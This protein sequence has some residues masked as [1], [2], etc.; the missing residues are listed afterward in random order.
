MYRGGP[1][2]AITIACGLLV[3]ACGDPDE[4]R[5]AS[6][7]DALTTI[8]ATQ[9]VDA[10]PDACEGCGAPTCT[11][12]VRNGDETGVDCGG[13]R[14]APCALGDAC[15]RH[16]D[17]ATRI[18]RLD[19]CQ[20]GRIVGDYEIAFDY[21]FLTPAQIR[22][23]LLTHLIHFRVTPSTAVPAPY[24]VFAGDQMAFE[25]HQAELVSLGHANG[26]RVL[27]AIAGNA[28]EMN[29]VAKD[30]TMRNAFITSVV[31]Y[32]QTHGYDG[33]DIDWEPPPPDHPDYLIA[34]ATELRVALNAWQPRG[35]L[36]FDV[37]C[38]VKT[39]AGIDYPTLAQ[40]ADQVNAMCYDLGGGDWTTRTAYNAA[41]DQPSCT[42]YDGVWVSK[43]YELPG[44]FST[45]VSMTQL[46]MGIPF[47]GRIFVGYS[48]PCQ[49]KGTKDWG[50]VLTPLDRIARDGLASLGL[51]WDTGA[52]VPWVGGVNGGYGNPFFMT[53]EDEQSIAAKAAYAKS[54]GVGGVM[55]W[56]LGNGIVKMPNGPPAQPLL[57]A[58]ANAYWV[59]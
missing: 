28:A 17:C 33:I 53:Y 22:W 18:C 58:L 20:A 55:I 16:E 40:T 51:Q 48:A 29:A 9:N 4:T 23:D 25:Q 10:S 30:A 54:V 45:G 26:V 44:L 35:E 43:S 56:T 13:S 52:K 57:E 5:D 15:I 59:H 7:V 41:L 31:S 8:D 1:R 21:D 19:R 6:V 36:A 11:D 42:P 37:P 34:L 49:L 50:P 27:L 14:C 38:G 24:W 3:V 2:A 47:Y 46:G 32:A 12:G 39:W